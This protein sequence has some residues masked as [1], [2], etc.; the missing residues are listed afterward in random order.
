MSKF[1]LKIFNNKISQNPE[2]NRI[3]YESYSDDHIVLVIKHV[4]KFVKL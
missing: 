3:E 1:P 4:F 2:S